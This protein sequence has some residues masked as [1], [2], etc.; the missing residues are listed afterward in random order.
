MLRPWRSQYSTR[1]GTRAMVPS[2]F[3]ISQITPAGFRPARRARSTAASVWPA[4]SSTPPGRLLSGNTWPGW[5]R[6]RG[7]LAGSIAT[8]IVCA[9]SCA[10]IPVVTPSRASI[11]TVKGV[12]KEDSFLA[13]IRSRPSSSQRSGVS[14]RQIR[15]RPSLAMKLIASGVA[16]W[17]ASVRSPSFSRSSSSH[18]TTIRPWR[19]S[20]IACSIV[21][22]GVAVPG[23]L[24]PAPPPAA[25][26]AWRARPPRRSRDRP[27]GPRRAWSARASRGSARPP[28]RRPPVR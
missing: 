13:A 18:T 21:A 11:E 6:S 27:R 26:R 22:N 16:N 9:R 4:R 14:D 1:S 19:M 24:T 3:M 15:P 5:T 25:R 28:S 17:A 7:R 20:S 2:S 8:W 23:M 12:S 10:E